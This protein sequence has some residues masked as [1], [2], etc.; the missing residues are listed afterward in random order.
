MA[1]R[2]LSPGPLLSAERV[3]HAAAAAARAQGGYSAAD[4]AFPA[5]HATAACPISP[6]SGNPRHAAGLRLA[7]QRARIEALHRAHGG[8]VF[9]RKARRMP[10]PRRSISSRGAVT[11]QQ[12]SGRRRRPRPLREEFHPRAVASDLDSGKREAG[13][14]ARAGGHARGARPSGGDSGNRTHHA[15]SQDETIRNG[16]TIAL[17][18]TYSLERIAFGRRP[19][20]RAR[21]CMAW[22][23]P[24]RK[25][26]FAFCYRPHRF[27]VASWGAAGNA[28][29]EC[30]Q[31]AAGAAAVGLFHGLNQRLPR[32]LGGPTVATFHDLFVF[33]GE[34]STPEFRARFAAQARDAAER[35][36]TDYRRLGIHRGP[37]DFAAGRR[38]GAASA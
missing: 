23:A 31:A 38:A 19:S 10:C 28:A 6:E 33:T 34:Y 12:L 14:R 26:E 32:C 11:L 7:G 35:A 36:T 5:R 18:A 30:W 24:I 4:R 9:P 27:P 3:F 37:G 1:K 25:R 20:I 13:D 16:L 17:D 8:D 2:A 29:G 21:F 22:R 15:L